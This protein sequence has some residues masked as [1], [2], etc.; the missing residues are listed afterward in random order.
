[1]SARVTYQYADKWIHKLGDGTP[2]PNTG[3]QYT[4]AHTQIDA[5][6]NVTLSREVQLVVQGLNLN[7]EPFGYYVGLPSTYIQKEYYGKTVTAAF[8]LRY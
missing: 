6:L 1:M 5:S 7:N 2:D 4:M 8:R 3:D